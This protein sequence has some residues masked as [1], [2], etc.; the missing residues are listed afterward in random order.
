MSNYQVRLGP[1]VLVGELTRRKKTILLRVD[2]HQAVLPKM[3]HC[4]F[5]CSARG[6]STTLMSYRACDRLG[7]RSVGNIM[8]V[9][10]VYMFSFGFVGFVRFSF[11]IAY[12]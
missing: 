7:I 11:A 6:D 12:N 3:Y 10:F 2:L 1:M 9:G 5:S 4:C 8:S